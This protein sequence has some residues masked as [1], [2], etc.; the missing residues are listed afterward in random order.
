MS[1]VQE[2]F[3]DNP[4]GK[5]NEFDLEVLN[6]ENLRMIPVQD[7]TEQY[8][9]Q[10]MKND[11]LYR[12][13]SQISTTYLKMKL[14]DTL[15]NAKILADTLKLQINA[16]TAREKVLKEAIVNGRS[17]VTS[18]TVSTLGRVF[19]TYIIRD[20]YWALCNGIIQPPVN[21]E[22]TNTNTFNEIYSA[23]RCIGQEVPTRPDPCVFHSI[24]KY[25]TVPQRRRLEYYEE[26]YLCLKPSFNNTMERYLSVPKQIVNAT[27]RNGIIRSLADNTKECGLRV[28]AEY[29]YYP[30][31]SYYT[32]SLLPL[33]Y[34]TEKNLSCVL[35]TAW[36]V[37][38]STIENF[39][40]LKNDQNFKRYFIKSGSYI[41][42]VI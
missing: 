2:Q 13:K 37:S 33:E 36:H 39:E 25:E 6:N 12:S 14:E 30:Q 5:N 11:I 34:C 41:D 38:N 7:F 18:V 1:H 40:F 35:I 3:N 26:D 23:P 8:L 19:R 31:R 27:C 32:E 10:I 17:G 29:T 16:L 21:P 9:N 42:Q 24:I 15:Q 4:A 20:G 28:M 22:S